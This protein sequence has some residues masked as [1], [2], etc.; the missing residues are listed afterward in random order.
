M[1]NLNTKI[2]L[3]IILIFSFCCKAQEIQPLNADSDKFPN[4]TYYKDLD[5][6][7]NPYIGKYKSVYN[8]QETTLYITKED[9]KFR[10][11]L[12]KSF[13]EDVLVLRFIVKSSAGK[14]L[15]DTRSLD[16]ENNNIHSIGTKP[17][18][19]QVILYYEGTN[20]GVGWGKIILKKIN[21]K[22]ISWTYGADCTI[23]TEHDCPGNPDLTVYLPQ[24]EN[25]I[26]TKQ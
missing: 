16:V 5:G 17:K 9:R 4:N 21:A 7:L 23:L 25:L 11:L 8:G 12:K 20:C 18:L 3:Y 26:F 19:G 1:K 14:V 10:K 6:E 13:F 22:Q 24:T 2:Y 15:Q